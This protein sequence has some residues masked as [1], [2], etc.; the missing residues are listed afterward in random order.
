MIAAGVA[1][2]RMSIPLVSHYWVSDKLPL[3][4]INNWQKVT[5]ANFQRLLVATADDFR[6]TTPLKTRNKA[7]SRSLCTALTTSLR[8]LPHFIRIFAGAF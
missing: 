3:T 7:M 6:P 4:D 5:A 2:D 1:F 8:L